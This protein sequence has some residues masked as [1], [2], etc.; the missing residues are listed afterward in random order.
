V[1]EELS[2]R[3]WEKQA[4]QNEYQQ[5]L[6]ASLIRAVNTENQPNIIL[7]QNAVCRL[8][9][10][11]THF[12]ASS[13]KIHREAAYRIATASWQIFGE[14]Y[15]NLRE[16]ALL[17]LGRLGNFPTI[18]YLYGRVKDNR[19]SS[20]P[21]ALWFEVAAHEVENSV[22]VNNQVEVTLTNFQRRLWEA[23]E[24]GVSTAVTAPTSAGKSFAL[25]RY[26]ISVLI[27]RPCWAL[28]LV[29]TRTLINQVSASLAELIK[30]LG[31]ENI[32]ISTVPVVPSEL[33]KL[34]GIYVLTQERLQMLLQ[35]EESVRFRLAIVDEAQMVSEGSRGVILQSVIEKLRIQSPEVQL[36]FGSPQ[37]RNPQI[38]Q[39]L[40]E[41]ERAEVV[42]EQ[43]SPVAQNFI[44][45]DRNPERSRSFTISAQIGEYR[46]PLRQISLENSL[47]GQEKTLAYMSWMLGRNEKSLVYAGGPDRCEKLAERLFQLTQSNAAEETSSPDPDLLEFSDFIKEHVHPEYF[48]AESILRGVAFHY[49]YMPSIIR[50]TVEEYFDEGLLTFLV[51]TSTLLHGV[52]LPAKNLFLLNPTKGKN[53][54]ISPLEFWNLAGRAGRL[55]RDF[56]GNVFLINLAEWSSQ[57]LDG[58]KHQD[59]KPALNK[60]IKENSSTFLNFIQNQA[61][62]SGEHQS[63]ENVFVKVFNDYR[64]GRLQQTL[65]KILDSEQFE[66]R[67]NI[68]N[69]ISE[70]EINITVPNSVAERN[71]NVSIFRQ[72]EMLEYLCDQIREY[73][74]D[75]LI[76]LHP[77]QPWS[78]ALENLRNIFK[79]IHLL[80][81]KKPEENRSEYFFAPLALKWMRGDSLKRLIDDAY[82]Y[83][84]RKTPNRTIRIATI[85]RNVIGNIENELRFR[86]V[87]YMSCYIDLLVEALSRSG[88]EESIERIPSIPLFLEVG[89]SSN[90]M[91]NLISL[92]FSRTAATVLARRA[93]N[94][95]MAILE[96]EQWLRN[97]NW[98]NSGISSIILR[99]L[100]RILR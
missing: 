86:Y 60:V 99:E 68:E 54:P 78:E 71:I 61:H 79:L 64:Q 96:L 30:I 97:Q 63:L 57:P 23:L 1:I 26:L 28:Y 34:A 20:L 15:D 62:P 76:P 59:I 32:A 4:F 48:L 65:D 49:G 12:S 70:I 100:R 13:Q 52:N 5:L 56:E 33:G 8:L 89:A 66:L 2:S 73:G 58:I 47:K 90:T 92:G 21:Q 93:V 6:Q 9:Q 81:E 67:S 17:I 7:D 85:I 98:E 87:K 55:G 37:T 16:I 44:F 36:F 10:S 95:S 35:A 80:F 46:L 18:D 19:G 43:E 84:R 83:E 72:Q 88:H 27:R 91:V 51:C 74:V 24:T 69:V 53:I 45:V 29:P 77:R 75:H 3:I 50:K 94:E 22:Q 31:V 25:Q 14:E 40:F 41:L 82:E 39:Q 42:I 38:F 11:A